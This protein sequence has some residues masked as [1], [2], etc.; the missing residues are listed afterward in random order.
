MDTWWAQL[1]R[2]LPLWS[3]VAAWAIAQAIK[4]A[5]AWRKTREFDFRYFVSTGGMPS[6]HSAFACALA[7]SAGLH[8]GFDSPVFAIAAGFAIIVMFDAQSVRRAAGLQARL[9][10]QIVEELFKEHHLSGQKL[11]EL[12]GHTRLEVFFGMLLGIAV[13]VALYHARGG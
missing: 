7:T 6:A 4:M 8:S 13:A 11:A 2:N 12:L 9:L 1:G 5:L 10:N 3:G